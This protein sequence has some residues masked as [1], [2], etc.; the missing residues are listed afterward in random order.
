MVIFEFTGLPI[1]YLPRAEGFLQALWIPPTPKNWNPFIFLV[2]HCV[3]KSA[4]DLFTYVC[5]AAVG[6]Q[7]TCY[8]IHEVL[9]LLSHRCL[10]QVAVLV[11]Y[12]I[13]HGLSAFADIMH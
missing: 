1:P 13:M 2:S 12:R 7:V 10:E 8:K 3:D 4:L 9:L 5:A 11:M 6:L